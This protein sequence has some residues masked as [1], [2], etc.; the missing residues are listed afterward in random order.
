MF[1]H[2]PNARWVTVAKRAEAD[3]HF[4]SVSTLRSYLLRHDNRISHGNDGGVAM[5]VILSEMRIGAGG[6]SGRPYPSSGKNLIEMSVRGSNELRFRVFCQRR[7][8]IGVAS[9][10]RSFDH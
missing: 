3:W 9:H 4:H 6:N 10:P 1:T 7:R 8:T 2:F 5:S